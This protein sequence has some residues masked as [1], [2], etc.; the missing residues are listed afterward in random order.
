MLDGGGGAHTMTEKLLRVR[1]PKDVES[2]VQW[3]LGE[4]RALEVLGQ[5]SKRSIGRPPQT[6][7]K[8]DLSALCG[9]TLYEPAELVLSARAGT[10]LSEIEALLAAKGQRLAFEPMDC[11]QL[12]GGAAGRGTIGGTIAANLSGPRRLAAGAA[13]DHLLGFVAVSGRGE[14][15]RSGGRVVKNV[16]GYDLCKLMAG[17]WGTLAVLTEV[18]VKTLPKPETEATVVMSGLDDAT[19][20]R[21]MAAAM[22]SAC[23][24][25]GAAHLPAATAARFAMG[26]AVA[27][28]RALTA[29][30]LEGVAPSVAQRQAALLAQLRPLG[31]TATID[32][33]VSR[34]L[35][36]AIRDVAA[37]GASCTGAEQPLWRISTA[38]AKG[39]ELAAQIT[40][41]T[42][43][44]V[45]YDWAGG[46][47]W[48][49]TPATDA[50]A[51]AVRAAVR[52][53][54]GHATLVR[55]PAALRAGLDVF[56]PQEAGLA[57][58]T[59]RVKE[60][61]DPR[62][63]LNPGRMWAQV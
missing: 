40:S 22:G 47:I 45:L 42:A 17:S 32:D 9:V 61:F 38:P 55:G 20:S 25:S 53:F 5:G 50:A 62:R 34:R 46:L 6:E 41:A 28:G 14:T 18:T 1:D 8:L 58:L 2:A 33:T 10:A 29:L 51:A 59:K 26:E 35:W 36:V 48:V 3:A 11:G 56:E 13:R 21:A 7:L 15:F 57:A 52:A 43:A 63:V 4:G 49:A 23:E 44:E 31:E 30:R 37:F 39:H 12:M 24:V 54:G 16:T 19:A 27:A 60:S